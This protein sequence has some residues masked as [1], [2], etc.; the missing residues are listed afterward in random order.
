MSYEV[1]KGDITMDSS[2]EKS[3]YSDS[4]GFMRRA[5]EL[6]VKA[7]GHTSPNPLVGAV[8]V[9]DGRIIG[10]GYHRQY[11]SLHAERDALSRCI[12]SP[13]GADMY[14][15]LEPCC[16]Y[17]KQPPCVYAI[18]EA[19]I[20]RVYVGSRDPNPLVSG[21]GNEYLRS[22]GIEVIEDY[23]RSECDEINYVFFH[24]ITT[25]KPYVIMKYAMTLDGK[26]A[27][28][29]GNSKWITSE[30]ARKKVH[31]DRN[32]YTAIMVGTGTVL[33][34]NPEL[35]CRLEG[36]INP[37]RIICDSHLKTPI[38]SIIVETAGEVRTIIATCMSEE[39]FEPYKNKGCEVIHISECDGHIDLNE[40]MITL[41]SM[42]IDSILLEGGGTL[43]WSALNSGIVSRVQAYIAPKLIG[44]GSAPSPIRGEGIKMMNDA[45]RIVNSRIIRLGD[46]YMIEGD[47]AGC[48]QE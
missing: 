47:I 2:A 16:H 41:G 5:I 36:G 46:D 33:A 39:H 22:K 13:E 18:E 8:I 48:S 15:T 27:S 23:M 6:A 34:D 43:N 32:R 25:K 35:T 26:I 37:V 31:E 10:E 45:I 44:G 40:L 38:D 29:T 1:Q 28:V 12:E 4:S 21:K 17:G 19:G 42:N 14:V 7:E 24:Y 11:G 9:R 30:A 20:K 3:L